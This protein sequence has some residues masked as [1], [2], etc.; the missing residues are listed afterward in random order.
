MGTQTHHRSH[1]KTDFWDM[2]RENAQN[3]EGAS[4]ASVARDIT[5]LN[6][7]EGRRSSQDVSSSNMSAYRFESPEEVRRRS[8]AKASPEQHNI[9]CKTSPDKPGPYDYILEKGL[10]GAETASDGLELV[11]PRPRAMSLSNTPS[12][13]RLDDCSSPAPTREVHQFSAP[14]ALGAIN[15]Y[16]GKALSRNSSGQWLGGVDHQSS[17]AAQRQGQVNRQ[18]SGFF[19][20]I[21]RHYGLGDPGKGYVAGDYVTFIGKD[22]PPE[23]EK[24]KRDAWKRMSCLQR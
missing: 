6:L 19:S 8:A 20:S 5:T 22:A 7:S 13:L 16:S 15:R 18:K 9:W 4:N 1:W 14:P 17:L 2:R 12:E 11:T 21:G 3:I 10:S 23:K 24:R